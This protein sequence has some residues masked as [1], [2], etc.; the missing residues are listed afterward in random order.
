MIFYTAI[1]VMRSYS[2]L[3]TKQVSNMAPKERCSYLVENNAKIGKK[4]LNRNLQRWSHIALVK[5]VVDEV[6]PRSAVRYFPSA[7]VFRIAFWILSALSWSSKWRN[8]ETALNSKAV[9][10]AIFYSDSTIEVR[11]NC[12]CWQTNTKSLFDI[13]QFH[14]ILL[15]RHNISDKR[16]FNTLH[17]NFIY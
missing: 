14:K 13:N 10:F 16:F 2:P 7:I 6:P 15:R 9:G 8:I 12:K 11:S 3:E 17:F 5:S 4:N 1:T